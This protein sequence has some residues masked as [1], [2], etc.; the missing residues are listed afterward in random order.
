M[1][2]RG[3]TLQTDVP[4]VRR[5]CACVRVCG[6][7]CVW[8]CG[9]VGVWVCAYMHVCM[10]TCMHVCGGHRCPDAL[11]AGTTM[12]AR[13]RWTS[14]NSTSSDTRAGRRSSAHPALALASP[15]PS[16]FLALQ[17]GPAELGRGPCACRSRSLVPQPRN[18]LIARRPHPAPRRASSARCC[19]RFP[20]SEQRSAARRGAARRRAS[21]SPAASSDR[22][23]PT[24]LPLS[25]GGRR[26]EPV[27][28]DCVARDTADSAVRR[29]HAL[30]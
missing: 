29:L 11:S 16:P 22:T 9:C 26:I 1:R 30:A 4:G 20:R 7:V 6:C 14:T 13:P 12:P 23:A 3:A 17:P 10:H 5:V 21:G 2:H 27:R 18:L 25:T 19:C 24:P 28:G 8:V 15:F